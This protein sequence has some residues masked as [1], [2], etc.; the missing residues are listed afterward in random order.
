MP[1]IGREIRRLGCR[2]ICGGI[3]MAKDVIVVIG[4]GG[5]G[6]AIARRQGFGKT[7]LLADWNLTPWPR[8]GPILARQAMPW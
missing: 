7:V 4:A 8:P 6:Q 5:I 2:M 1:Y 3:E